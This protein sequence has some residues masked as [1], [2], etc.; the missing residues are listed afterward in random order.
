MTPNK[1]EIPLTN[2]FMLIKL[3]DPLSSLLPTV[4]CNEKKYYF[5]DIRKWMDILYVTIIFPYFPYLITSLF[6]YVLIYLSLTYSATPEIFSKDLSK[7]Q[8][9]LKLKLENSI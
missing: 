2:S 7:E 4:K 5:K 9:S 6:V 1:E 8:R 3:S